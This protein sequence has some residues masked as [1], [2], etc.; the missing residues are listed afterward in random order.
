MGVLSIDSQIVGC[1]PNVG[2]HYYCMFSMGRF[3]KTGQTHKKDE[4]LIVKG[5]ECLLFIPPNSRRRQCP[6]QQMDSGHS[7]DG[8]KAT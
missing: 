1:N 8:G 7:T 6:A 4:A 2:F 5:F 3:T